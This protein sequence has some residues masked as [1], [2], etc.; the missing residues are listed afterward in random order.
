MKR[1]PLNA[2]R[3]VLALALMLTLDV[4]QAQA[5]T[6]LKQSVET[7]LNANPDVAAKLNA[8]RASA[9]AVD[10]ARAGW[11]PRVDLTAGVG[12]ENDRF[13]NRDPQSDTLTRRSVGVGLTQVLWDGLGTRNDVARTGHERLA[14]YFELIET[15][16]QTALEAARAHYDVLRYRRLVQLAEDNYV[17]HK[18]ATLQIGSRFKA[19]VGRGVDVEQSG[20]RLALAESNLST[21][22]ANLHD[23]TARYQRVVGEAPPKSAQLS[24]PMKQAIPANANDAVA[25]A[26]SQSA[27][28]SASV[29]SMR[30]ARAAVAARQSVYQP[31]IEARVRT[32]GGRNVEGLRDQTRNST[33]EVVLNWNLFNGGADQARVR[34]QVNL[35]AQAAD[36]R[37]KA[38]RD[39]RQT[40]SIAYND[41]AKLTEQLAQLDRNTLSIEKARDAY[42]Q[43]FD[44]GQRSLLD[45]L[46]AENELYTAKRSYANAEYDL[47]I[48][49]VRAHA[50][51]NQLLAQLGLARNAPTDS[52]AAN[53]AAGPD[54]P[55]RCP[56]AALPQAATSRAELD[57]RAERIAASVPPAPNAPARPA[58]PKK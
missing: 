7:A 10:V 55:G 31:R 45:L 23:V 30:A 12:R 58:E 2:N 18:Y 48:A 57:A 47:N 52:D 27:A 53:W 21:E 32:E 22:V 20:A 17:Q 25:L 9:D 44:I 43:Q 41:T 35:M 49:Y 54:A 1:H 6:A 38:C 37:D 13:K 50:A 39:V 24:A 42:R 11:L 40:V 4:A 36:L 16:E 3:F 8:Y 14:R 56:A 5:D 29:E 34:Q 46:N 19:G 51:M 33:A 26:V 28:V 15:T